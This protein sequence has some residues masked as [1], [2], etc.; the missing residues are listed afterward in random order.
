MSATKSMELNVQRRANATPSV[1]R[2]A[3]VQRGHPMAEYLTYREAASR[4]RRSTRTIKRWRRSGMP[5]TFDR[6]GRRVVAEGTL[7]A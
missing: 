5:M 1:K 6:R 4:V 3:V 2:G 7:L